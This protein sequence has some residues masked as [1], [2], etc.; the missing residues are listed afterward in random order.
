[1]LIPVHNIENIQ[2]VDNANILLDDKSGSSYVRAENVKVNN[3]Y[4]ENVKTPVTNDGK[5]CTVTNVTKGL[6]I[7]K[8]SLLNIQ[9]TDPIEPTDPIDPIV[10]ITI[11]EVVDTN[12]IY[13]L[14]P[15]L[16]SDQIKKIIESVTLV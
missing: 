1:M 2:L 14:N 6:K 12:A 10:E 16:T 3:I 13:K 4:Y 7:T 9:N 8:N 11:P 15:N 5:N